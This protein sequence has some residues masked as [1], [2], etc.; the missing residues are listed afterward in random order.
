[1]GYGPKSDRSESPEK[2]EAARSLYAYSSMP[3]V[4]DRS[5]GHQGHRARCESAA[6]AAV[7]IASG[8]AGTRSKVGS[9]AR[10]VSCNHVAKRTG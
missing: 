7:V 9:A 3:R 1:M 5:G 6:K 10:D 8:V 2:K 4:L